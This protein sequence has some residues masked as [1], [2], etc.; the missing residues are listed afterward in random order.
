MTVPT[1]PRVHIETFGCTFNQSDSEVLAGLLVRAGFELADSPAE[2]DA[3]IVN[4]CTVKS[5]TYH[6][7]RKRLA[8][9]SGSEEGH[10]PAVI[11]AGC[12]PRVYQHSREFANF[13]QLGP[14]NLADAP[15]VVARALR[16]ERIVR[17]AR[18][19]APR[20]ALPHI[21]RNPAVEIIPINKGCLGSCT[22]CQTVIARGRLFS[23]PEDEIVE[24]AARAASTG[25][26]IICLTSQDCGAYGLDRGTNLPRL[27]RRIAEIPGDFRVRLGMANPDLIKLY[28]D[29]LVEALA[30]PRFFR[31]AHVPVQ[32][33]SDA[34][35]Q[36]M[37]RLYTADDFR[38]I[39][40]ALRR[41]LPDITIATDIITG[42]PTETEA[43]FEASL[44]LVG[45][46]RLP[47][48]NRSRFSPRPGTRAARLA[49]L[50]AIVSRERSRRMA[51][52]HRRLAGE[53]LRAHTD[54][55][56]GVI[57]ESNP[58]PGVALARDDAYRP[59]I[60]RGPFQPGESLEVRILGA[61]DFHL[62]GRPTG[63]SA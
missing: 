3:V 26:R 22:F 7:V 50:P 37:N 32:S 59:V 44:A 15:E 57:V 33:G 53:L 28:L 47:V 17:V 39:V 14:D 10:R 5:R 19:E 13:A 36:A 56:A 48:V 63:R 58:R 27:L 40:T 8:D 55:T 29:D 62:L 2:A 52:F 43:D 9:L 60:L 6:D 61:E 4:S 18:T 16:G 35:L 34:V 45:E 11:L 38:R 31:F 25:A 54:R 20:L 46:L 23:F 1:R 42:F 49:P 12:V 24:R 41:R 51:A 21:R 30:H